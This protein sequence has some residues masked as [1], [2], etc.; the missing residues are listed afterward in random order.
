MAPLRQERLL[1]LR[2]SRRLL[3]AR[4]VE[5]PTPAWFKRP[6]PV[7]R[8][9]PV[10]R[11]PAA[12]LRY[13]VAPPPPAPRPPGTGARAETFASVVSR[14]GARPDGAATP[15]GAFLPHYHGGPSASGASPECAQGRGGGDDG[16]SLWRTARASPDA[17]APPGRRLGGQQSHQPQANETP[18]RP[19]ENRVSRPGA[20]KVENPCP[21]CTR[22]RPPAES[23][24]QDAPPDGHMGSACPSS[25][26][27]RTSRP[28]LL[29][30]R[31]LLSNSRLFP[32]S[33]H[34]PSVPDYGTITC[35]DFPWRL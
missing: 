14:L 23:T 32:R 29:R 28:A 17:W 20:L 11:A 15:V 7:P 4:L 30:G 27:R 31:V 24:A 26:E 33:P 18:H 21:S 22:H 2:P 3:H 8:P 34:R 19:S 25:P 12:P 16:A 5:Q 10:L 13:G 9:S 35:S 1:P 6:R